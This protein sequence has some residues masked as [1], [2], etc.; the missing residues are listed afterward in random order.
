MSSGSN[1][2]AMMQAQ[3]QQQPQGPGSTVSGSTVG[4]TR[5]PT[6]TNTP[7]QYAALVPIAPPTVPGGQN[8]AAMMAPPPDPYATL[9][10]IRGSYVTGQWWG[11]QNSAGGM[12]QMQQGMEQSPGGARFSHIGPPASVSVPNQQAVEKVTATYDY[13]AE[14]P[15]E[16]SFKEN[17]V[18]VVIRRNED[19]WWEGALEQD[20]SQRGLFPSNY[21]ENFLMQ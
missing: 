14:R 8:Q 3:Q 19:G 20:P 12:A 11:Q 9:S 18:I 5:R 15:D 10:R 7:Q 6:L 21:V 4:T 1:L 2:M 16:L 17:S 13:T